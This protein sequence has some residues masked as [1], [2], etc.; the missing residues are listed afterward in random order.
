MARPGEAARLHSN[1]DTRRAR[2]HQQTKKSGRTN[3]Q[4]EARKGFRPQIDRSGVLSSPLPRAN[5]AKRRLPGRDEA[6]LD[7]FDL[8]NIMRCNLL[9]LFLWPRSLELL[10]MLD[11]P[12]F[13]SRCALECSRCENF[14]C[15]KNWMLL[16]TLAVF[17]LHSCPLH[18]APP[19]DNLN[20]LVAN[21]WLSRQISQKS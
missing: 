6:R 11:L 19:N 3:E 18:T 21:G 13:V 7:F 1:D 15:R 5:K 14:V 12:C 17:M 16:P 8:A 2:M 10:W 20:S 9:L 4:L